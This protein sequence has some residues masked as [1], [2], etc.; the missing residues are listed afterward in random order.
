MSFVVE[1]R[2]ALIQGSYT[3]SKV[4]FKNLSSNFQ[5]LAS[6]VNDVLPQVY[7]L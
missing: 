1:E 2:L 5:P 6:D 7:K 4:E 3:F